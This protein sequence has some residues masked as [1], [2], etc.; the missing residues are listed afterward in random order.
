TAA[1]PKI[2]DYPFTTLHPNLG[3]VRSDGREFVLADIPG[4][5]EGAHEGVGL[6]VRFLGHVER[7]R[8]L[9]HLVD[10]TQEDPAEAY[11]IVRGELD[12]YGDVLAEKREV[13]A[14]SKADA[15]PEDELE[16]I[17]RKLAKACGH[18]P[19]VLSAATR[20]GVEAALRAIGRI[21]DE[22]KLEDPNMHPSAKPEPWRP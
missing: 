4:L 8:V 18:T 16:K 14:L 10:G 3:V 5:I 13:V 17:K 22:G 1:K 21:I 7:C 15:I 19:L 6:G 20:V 11:R 12:A 2:A 9:L